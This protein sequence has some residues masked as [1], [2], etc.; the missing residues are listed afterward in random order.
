MPRLRLDFATLAFSL[1]ALA[2][3]RPAAAAPSIVIAPPNVD[4][5]TIGVGSTQ[6]INLAVRNVGNSGATV[7]SASLLDVTGSG[8]FSTDN[9]PLAGP[10]AIAPGKELDIP[11]H[12]SPRNVGCVTAEIDLVTDDPNAKNIHVPVDGCATQGGTLAAM[13][14]SIDFGAVGVGVLST[15]Q[16]LQIVNG[17]NLPI[18]VQSVTVDGPDAQAFVVSGPGMFTLPPG[19]GV[20]FVVTF[21][22]KAAGAASARAL[23]T[24]QGQAPAAVTLTGMGAVATVTSQPATLDFSSIPVG[25]KSTPQP[26]QV[27]FANNGLPV[28]IASGASTDP[29]FTVDTSQ[30]TSVAPGA[31]AMVWATFAPTA[32]GARSATLSIVVKGSP[33][34]ITIATAHGTGTA[35]VPNDQ[36][37]LATGGCALGGTRRSP[38]PMV[39]IIWG[40]IAAMLIKVRRGSRSSE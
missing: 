2:A 11:V 5:G 30:A 39:A 23:F 31:T 26:I 15:P 40:L 36:P 10:A 17:G 8:A 18:T 22:P 27:T 6:T 34:P 32:T 29:A 37:G 16:N 28:Q 25:A 4:F 35:S 33:T 13:P 12:F 7:L 38:I 21:Q 20:T 19:K 14:G 9:L 1:L 3:P 24:P